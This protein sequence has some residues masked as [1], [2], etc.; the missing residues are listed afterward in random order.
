MESTFDT[1]WMTEKPK[2]IRQ[3]HRYR[4]YAK[5]HGLSILDKARRE[6]L[7]LEEEIGTAEAARAGAR[8]SQR[9]AWLHPGPAGPLAGVIDPIPRACV[10]ANRVT[11]AL[12][13]GLPPLICRSNFLPHVHT[14]RHDM[15]LPS[16]VKSLQFRTKP[17]LT[18][19][20][21]ANLHIGKT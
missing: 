19:A 1:E 6:A 15:S 14:G 16:C 10:S 17:F 3:F 11:A 5:R 4:G 13:G 7:Q 21:R 8:R 18:T 2:G 20:Y 12:S 9:Q